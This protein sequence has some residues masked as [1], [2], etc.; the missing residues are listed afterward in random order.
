MLAKLGGR[1]R[2][3]G[4][5]DSGRAAPD[6]A[7]VTIV[8]PECIGGPAPEAPTRRPEI[9]AQCK[10]IAWPVSVLRKA[11]TGPQS[12]Y[13]RVEQQHDQWFMS[14]PRVRRNRAPLPTIFGR[15]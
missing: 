3:D 14:A 1:A 10:R 11:R 13:H 5:S 6:R 4:E 12:V 2:V 8:G 9:S 7:H 15:E